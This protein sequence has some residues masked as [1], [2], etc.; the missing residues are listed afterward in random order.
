MIDLVPK[1]AIFLDAAFTNRSSVITDTY[2]RMKRH[3]IEFRAV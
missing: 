1:K 2:Y 3:E